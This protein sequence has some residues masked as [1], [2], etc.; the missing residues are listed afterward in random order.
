MTSTGDD[1]PINQEEKGDLEYRRAQLERLK[2][3]VVDWKT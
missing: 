2:E 3:E 1:D